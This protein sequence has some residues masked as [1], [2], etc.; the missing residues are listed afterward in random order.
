MYCLPNQSIKFNV[1]ILEENI[2]NKK[3]QRDGV[4]TFAQS[5]LKILQLWNAEKSD[6][7]LYSI[8]ANLNGHYAIDEDVFISV[9]TKFENGSF[10]IDD[11]YFQT[12]ALI[13]EISKVFKFSD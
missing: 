2:I 13:S 12:N 11:S 10:K 6:G 4:Y 7:N 1:L 3:L 8:I 9:P 5:V